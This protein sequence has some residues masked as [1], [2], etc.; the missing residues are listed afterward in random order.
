[1][2][3]KHIINWFVSS[4][5]NE[6]YY[7][8]NTN[9]AIFFFQNIESILFPQLFRF[10]SKC[11]HIFLIIKVLINEQLGTNHSNNWWAFH[12]IFSIN[13]FSPELNYG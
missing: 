13:C 6:S 10:Q 12:S 4:T 1:M 2:K 9:E 8:Y 7:I 3:G 5:P 11:I